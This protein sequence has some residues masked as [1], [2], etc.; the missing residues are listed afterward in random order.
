[1]QIRGL[2]PPKNKKDHSITFLNVKKH[3]IDTKFTFVAHLF[4]M[5]ETKAITNGGHIGLAA[6][7][8]P[9]VTDAGALAESFKYALSYICAKFGAFRQK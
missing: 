2:D 6:V 1:M 4:Q 9:K 5:L 8:T 7:A 3:E